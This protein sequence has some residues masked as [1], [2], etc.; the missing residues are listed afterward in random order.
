M[1]EL[2]RRGEIPSVRFGRHV[3]VPASGFRQWIAEQRFDKFRATDYGHRSRLGSVKAGRWQA[4]GNVSAPN[5]TFGSW[6][7]GTAP[8]S[9]GGRLAR[10]GGRRRPS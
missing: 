1:Y 3:R 2:A 10:A 8:G 6:T 7:T 9:G 4:S 5:G